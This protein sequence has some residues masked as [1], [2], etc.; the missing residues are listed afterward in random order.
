MVSEENV[1]EIFAQRLSALRRE[2]GITQL[3]LA[4]DLNYSDKA[5]SKWERAESVPDACTLV[6]LAEYFGVSIDYLLGGELAD[7]SPCDNKAKKTREENIKLKEVL[8]TFIPLLSVVLVFVIASVVFFVFKSLDIWRGSQQ[9]AFLYAFAGSAVVLVVF[10]H[11][12][13]GIIHRVTSVSLLI[14]LLGFSAYFTV[15]ITEFKFIFIPCAA[16]QVACFLAY[17][18]FYKIKKSIK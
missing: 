14:W 2:K 15:N 10:S 4:D 7:N 6:K 16:A 9:L 12:W 18:F 1:K 3:T 13:G 5:V 17:W 8:H 11:L